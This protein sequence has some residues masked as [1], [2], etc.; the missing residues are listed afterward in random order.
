MFVRRS[1]RQHHLRTKVVAIMNIM[2]QAASTKKSMTPNGR[3]VEDERRDS[4]GAGCAKVAW[5]V[6]EG[7]TTRDEGEETE[8]TTLMD[9]G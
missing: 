9:R 6:S 1:G 7:P 8:T 5:A 4:H 3:A 2:A